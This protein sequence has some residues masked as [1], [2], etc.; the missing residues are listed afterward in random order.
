MWKYT[1]NILFYT[2]LYF[3]IWFK[4]ISNKESICTWETKPRVKN[5]FPMFEQVYTLKDIINLSKYEYKGQF[6]DKEMRKGPGSK[7]VGL[8]YKVASAVGL[9]EDVLV[10]S[11]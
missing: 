9:T 1:Q 6:T 7:Q 8:G 4:Y 5:M 2:I 10:P 3:E 11:N